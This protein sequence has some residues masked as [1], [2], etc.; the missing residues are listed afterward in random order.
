MSKPNPGVALMSMLNAYMVSQ[1]VYAAAKLGVADYLK[2]GPLDV[3]A[4]AKLSGAHGASLLRV[5]RL[6]AT[7]GVFDEP[8][9]GTFALTPMSKFLCSDTRNSLKGWAI[10][11]GEDFVW[12]PWGNILHSVLTGESAFKHTF[13]TDWAEYLAQ[14]PDASAA[15]DEG[16]RS[17]SGIKF[18]AVAEAYD[19]SP[20]KTVADI[21]GGNGGLITA[22]LR[23]FPHL[24]GMLCD[25][26]H[27][28]A[29]SEVHLAAANLTDRCTRVGIDMFTA[30][31]TGADVYILA[32]VL[33]DWDDERAVQVLRNCRAVLPNE[34]RVLLVEMVLGSGEAEANA[35]MLDLEMLIITEGGR[36]R[37]KVEFAGVLDAAGLRLHRV[38]PTKSPVSILEAV[39]LL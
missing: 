14:H 20:F 10:M 27:V 30:I 12:R 37:S 33:H 5:M 39:P 36:E 3:S 31:P 13:G 4:L 28:V 26:P 22:V 7:H 6:L 24:N 29:E 9:P 15:F 16:M 23:K 21:G 11:R 2:N 19:F 1:S 32:N 17:I 8:S 18:W 25:L 34:G 38:I 35:L